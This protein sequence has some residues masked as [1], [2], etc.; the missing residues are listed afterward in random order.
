MQVEYWSD[1]RP[2]L[3]L[4][5]LN[6]LLPP[7]LG[8]QRSSSRRWVHCNDVNEIQSKTNPV[9]VQP[10]NPF[11]NRINHCVEVFDQHWEK[12]YVKKVHGPDQIRIRYADNRQPP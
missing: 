5:V 9:E 3:A 1:E 6:L 2:P 7:L 10:E 11:G 12:V 8:N 4:G